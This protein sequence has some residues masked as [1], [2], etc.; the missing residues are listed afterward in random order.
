MSW[1]LIVLAEN[2][3]YICVARFLV[4]ASG[5]GAYL[6]I[7]GFVAE[8]ADDQCVRVDQNDREIKNENSSTFFSL[9]I[10]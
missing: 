2:V 6:C 8:I 4:G 5:G 1:L 9:S 10:A 7:P 3:W